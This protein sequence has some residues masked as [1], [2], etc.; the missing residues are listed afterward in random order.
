MREPGRH[1]ARGI[2]LAGEDGGLFVA[3]RR[4][5][6]VD[7][8]PVDIGLV[9]DVV[10]VEVHS[11]FELTDAQLADLAQR[12]E[13][14]TGRKVRTTV[15]LDKELI[16][17]VKVVIGD[18]VIDG[19]ARGQLGALGEILL[20]ITNI[21]TAVV[22]WPIARRQSETLALGYVASRVVEAVL[23]VVGLIQVFNVHI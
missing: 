23:I 16:G 11:A 17:G 4:G 19:S 5:A 15:Q 9:G 13:K 18:K 12:L 6:V 14:K 20:A 22:L 21:G 7:G 1:A 3:A 2:G 10:E 8:T